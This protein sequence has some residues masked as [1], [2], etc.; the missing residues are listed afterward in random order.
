LLLRLG[1][2]L[3]G[4]LCLACARFQKHAL[5]GSLELLYIGLSH[6]LFCRSASNLHATLG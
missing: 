1:S 2:L 6:A 4:T 5:T 3:L